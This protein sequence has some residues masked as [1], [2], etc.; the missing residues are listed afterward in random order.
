MGK[1]ETTEQQM[2]RGTV[3]V[4]AGTPVVYRISYYE[5]PGRWERGTVVLISHSAVEMA[6]VAGRCCVCDYGL[7]RPLRN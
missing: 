2:R 1:G 4:E 7:C 5:G 3:R 6:L